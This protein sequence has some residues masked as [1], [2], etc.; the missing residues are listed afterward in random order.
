MADTR[1]FDVERKLEV[2]HH[3]PADTGRIDDV[4]GANVYPATGP[5]PPGPAKSVTA[6]QLGHPRERLTQ[7]TPALEDVALLVGR[8]VFGGF[9][10]YN[11]INHFVSR[12]MLTDY[13]RSKGVPAADAAVPASGL[14]ILAGG[15]SLLAGRQPKMGAGLIAT[16]LLGV[17]PLMHAFW[18][19]RGH[20]QRMQEMVNFTKNMALAGGAMMAAARPEPWPYTFRVPA[21]NTALVPYAG[22]R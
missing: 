12:R 9:F 3:A 8:T 15:L 1:E 10:L 13:A 4:R 7:R 19:E 2:P 5:Y 20:E 22:P 21:R 11:G 17:S 6:A 16:F 14:L 18:K